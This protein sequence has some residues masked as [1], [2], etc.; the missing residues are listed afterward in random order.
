M[1]MDIFSLIKTGVIASGGDPQ[2]GD[3][4]HPDD[5]SGNAKIYNP[6]EHGEEVNLEDLSFSPLGM[7]PTQSGA[8]QFPGAMDPGTPICYIKNTGQAGGI[9]L[10]QINSLKKGNGQSGGGGGNSRDL[11]QGKVSELMSRDI[12]VSI[13][14]QIEE[15]TERGV[16]VRKIKEKGDKHSL[17]LLDGLP[18]HGALFDM[19]GFRLPEVKKVPTAKQHN[20]QMMTNNLMEQLP[21]QI[22]SLAQMFQG[23]MKNGKGGGTGGSSAAQAGGLGGGQSYWD[24]INSALT[25]NMSLALNSLSNLIQG[26]ETDNGVGYVTGGVVHY[27]IYLE[28]AVDLLSQVQTLD[29]LM[30]VM[31]RL[32]WDTSIMGQEALDNVVVQIENAWGTALQEVDVNGTITVTYDTA[33]AQSNF[34]N[35]MS[36]TAYS[37]GASS[38][39]STPSGG[40]GGGGSGGGSGGAGQLQSMMGQI[41]GQASGTLQDMWKRLAPSQEKEATQMHKKLTQQDESQKQKQINQATTE[42]GDPLNKVYYQ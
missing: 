22:M 25:P 32:Q 34:A 26:H 42:G 14:P 12:G 20:D 30:Y 21:G 33:N 3:A 38:A 13:P 9:I 24:D 27:G 36:N 11:M 10:G 28:N 6:L 41:F 5:H 8:C 23:L 29:D 40:G 19:S 35:S 4:D 39:P 37:S 16:K 18:I 17:S 15:T 7:N 31:S 2:S 1:P